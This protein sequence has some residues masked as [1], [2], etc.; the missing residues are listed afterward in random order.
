M[1]GRNYHQIF[2]HFVWRVKESEPLLTDDIRERVHQAIWEK[3]K[4]LGCP[5]IAI[6]SI[7]DHIHL[8]V[9]MKP[10]IS[11]AELIKSVKGSSSHYI[12]Q[13]LITDR[14]FHWQSSYGVFSISKRIVPK[15]RDYVLN[16]RQHHSEGPVF[17]ELERTE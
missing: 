16:Q 15:T 4:E 13:D 7:E 14:P 11:P 1:V 17:Q 10:S 2:N 6:G 12:S 8:L 3:C 9:E 5:P